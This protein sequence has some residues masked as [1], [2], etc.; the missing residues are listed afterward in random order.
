MDEITMLMAVA[1]G[2]GECEGC[3]QAHEQFLKTEEREVTEEL[4]AGLETLG[5]IRAARVA[6]ARKRTDL[7]FQAEL[8]DLLKGNPWDEEPDSAPSAEQE[9]SWNEEGR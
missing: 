5:K 1:L 2:C 8:A 6:V 3:L 9:R 4:M 7:R